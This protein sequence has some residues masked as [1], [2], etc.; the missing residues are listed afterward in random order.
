MVSCSALSLSLSL[1]LGLAC[2][3]GASQAGSER[4]CSSIRRDVPLAATVASSKAWANLRGQADSVR[5]ESRRLLREAQVRSSAAAAPAG[6]CP[7]YC[8]PPS[9]PLIVLSTVPT[10]FLEGYDQA[11]MCERLLETTRDEPLRF[12]R[13]I[14]DSVDRL[15]D[16]VYDFTRGKGA[17]GEDLYRR[18]AGKCSPQYGW[19]I[20]QQGTSLAVDTEVICGHARDRE[21]GRYTLRSSLR[22]I[23]DAR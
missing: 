9:N 13:R 14:F 1:S 22:W 7:T 11:D 10:D 16:W 2:A 3:A 4:E 12:E 18:C 5:V 15:N 6:L 19:T 21:V 17:Q 23:C 8:R 20:S